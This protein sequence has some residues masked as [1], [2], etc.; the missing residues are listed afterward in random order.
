MSGLKIRLRIAEL[1]SQSGQ[2]K[3]DDRQDIRLSAIPKNIIEVNEV[4][5]IPGADATRRK[6][7]QIT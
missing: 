4:N 6:T 3:G 5:D 7:A 1:L 2:W